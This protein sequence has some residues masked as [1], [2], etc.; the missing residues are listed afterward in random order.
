M[1]LRQQEIYNENEERP[2]DYNEDLKL[3]SEQKFEKIRKQVRKI[4]VTN[5]ECTSSTEHSQPA[6][7][8]L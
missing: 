2:Y 4:K 7:T 3:E 5:I 1:P 6:M 8:K